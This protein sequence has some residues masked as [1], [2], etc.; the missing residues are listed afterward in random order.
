MNYDLREY[1]KHGHTLLYIKQTSSASLRH[2]AGH[3]K[4][5][6][7]DNPKGWG[8]ERGRKGVQDGGYTCIPVANS[9]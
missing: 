9:C 7:W 3:A 1:P 4:L 6:F 8:G 5:V 2:E